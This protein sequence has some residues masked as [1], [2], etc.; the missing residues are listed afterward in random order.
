MNLKDKI[1][2]LNI[3]SIMAI[4]VFLTLIS[5]SLTYNILYEK[6]DKEIQNI[7]TSFLD[8]QKNMMKYQVNNI[9]HLIETL[10]KAKFNSVKKN[11][12]NE[13]IHTAY[14]LQHT[15]PKTYPVILKNIEKINPLIN[16]TLSDLQGNLIYTHL[17][18][19]NKTKR[20]KLIKKMLSKHLNDIYFTHKTPKGTKITFQHIFKNYLLS[21]CL[22]EKNIDEFVKKRVIEII[23]SIRFGPKNNGYISIAEI[24]NYKGGK[25]FAKVVALPVKPSMVG[26]LLN[27]DKKDAKGKEYRKEYLKIAN[28]TGEGYVSY[29]FYKYSDKIIR[30]KLSYV[31]LYKPWNWLIFTSVFLD[32]VNSV[33]N[34][35]IA[36]FNKEMKKLFI[37]FTLISLI[38]I[39]ISYLIGKYENYIIQ[40]IIQEYENTINEK[41]KELEEL[42]RHLSKEVEKKSNELIQKMFTDNLTNLPNREK[43]LNDLEGNYVAII[44]INDFKEIND[45]FGIKEG[46]KI[47]KE[48]GEF[49]NKIYPTFKLSGDEY[50]ILNPSA[51]KL[52]Q[53]SSSIIEKLKDKKFKVNDQ[54]LTLSVNIGIGKTLAEADT[55]LKYSKTK[56]KQIIVFNKNLPILKDYEN[57]LKWK[58]IINEAIKNDKVIPFV[59]GIVE[60]KTKEIVKYECLIRIEH[61]NKIYSPFFFLEIA[62]KTHQYEQLQQIM[63]EKCFAKFSKMNFPFSVNI[64]IT[65][66]KNDNF[67]NFLIKKIKEYGVNE[68]LTIELLEDEELVKDKKINEIIHTL[69][70]LGVKIAIDDFGSGYSNFVYLIKDLP[71]DII[72]ID[73]TL[74]K[75]I[76]EDEKIYKLLSK[77][78]EIANT[79]NLETI[80]EF[81]ENEEIYNKLKEIGVQY[82]QGYYFSKPFS[83][84]ELKEEN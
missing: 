74:V 79:F 17:K 40:K 59:Q 61:E 58:N 20:K 14:I 53:I 67:R 8:N 81:V 64:A 12:K 25:H 62:K 55:A 54:E 47:I 71:I 51:A 4:I 82:S 42:N 77:I 31:K 57:N 84:Y 78:I 73:G 46:D 5:F 76:L 72:K 30:P 1:A 37:L 39:F 16:I 43:L 26:K 32:D 7:K 24:L 34:R 2:K 10:K 15:N 63:I 70:K 75:D 56:R 38:I 45:F 23:Y 52:R 36:I 69:K 21:T 65:D 60:N 41:N 49:L 83:I 35:K 22:Y 48:F 68:I 44:N 11:L 6:L 33:V 80:A 50:A 27:D 3:Y 28:T 13:N 18:D 29:W 66:L 9:I 19:Y